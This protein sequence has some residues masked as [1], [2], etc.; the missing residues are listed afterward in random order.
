MDYLNEI[1]K[2]AVYEYN[3]GLIVSASPGTGKTKTL[4]ARANKKLTNLPKHK[5]LALI[6]YTNAAA[7]EIASRLDYTENDVF[8]G[9]IHRFCLEYIL[10]P[11]SWIYKWDKPR[12][13]SYSDFKEFLEINKLSTIQL[14]D[15]NK[16]KKN[17]DGSLIIP[18]EWLHKITFEEL[19]RIYYDF[20]KQRKLIDFNEI[21]FRSYIIISKNLFTAKSV[22]NIFMEISVDEFQDTNIFQYEI[23]KKIKN[24]GDTS[25]FIVGD[26]KQKIYSFAGALNETFTIAKK[27]FGY[28]ILDLNYTYRSTKKIVTGYSKLFSDHPTLI[29]SSKYKDIPFDIRFHQTKKD[30]NNLYIKQII[31]SLIKAK[32]QVGNIAIL[33]TS[34][35]DAYNIGSYLREYF[36]IIGL[37]ALPH[38]N[39]SN[40]V[41]AILKTLSRYSVDSSIR[42]LKIIKRNIELLIL[43]KNIDFNEKEIVFATNKLISQFQKININTG[44]KESLLQYQ[45]IISL[46]FKIDVPEVDE[47]LTIVNDDEALNWNF[48]K[49]IE[50]LSGINGITINTIHQAKGL[51]YDFVIL[52]GINENRIPYQ[53][54]IDHVK[55]IYEELTDESIQNGRTLLYVGMS[56]AKIGLFILHNWKPS[57]FISQ[58]KL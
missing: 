4:V 50:T 27:D 31:D 37:G 47:I 3:N 18:T 38:S 36:N 43:E 49:Y 39:I 20:L 12:I 33:T 19:S 22:S 1:Q 2:Q 17:L 53:R 46:I 30:D 35:F 23:L 28:E 13:A 24:N 11:F 48:K 32:A 16:I 40:T 54:C 10:R 5:K 25:F 52:N 51:E 14:E 21:L 42:N 57:M 26:E 7:D 58:I 55:Y 15:L 6:T 8:I 44:L 34:W 56:R 9:T 41:F 29:N 45:N